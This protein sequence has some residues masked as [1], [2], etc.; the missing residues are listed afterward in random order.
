[1]PSQRA[2]LIDLE[3]NK[4]NPAFPYKHI[5]KSGH[6][7]RPS[8]ST[9]SIIVIDEIKVVEPEPVHEVVV[10]EEEVKF[11]PLVVEELSASL[12]EVPVE[13]IVVEEKQA[14]AAAA[15]EETQVPK[16]R[17]RKFNTRV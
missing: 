7:A 11:E 15:V 13:E 6:L 9:E 4:L 3:K 10:H 16:K 1:M 12:L 2:I 17:G 8:T 14:A 5:D